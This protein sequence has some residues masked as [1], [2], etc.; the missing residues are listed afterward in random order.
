[1]IRKAQLD[2][3]YRTYNR[4]EFVHPD[5]IE[6]LYRYPDV[7]DREIAGVVA[8]VLAFG[9]VAQ[10]L[11]SVGRVLSPMGDSPCDWILQSTR[12][13]L[14]K[15]FKGFRHRF[16]GEAELIS[17][18]VAIR[19]L[20]RTHGSLHACFTTGLG[21]GDSDLR[22][23][24]ARFVS[25]LGPSCG[26]LTPSPSL[27]SACK[28]WNLFLRWMVRHDDV[29]PGGWDG[30]SPRLLIVPLDVH[31]ARIGRR[32]GFTARKTPGIRMAVDITEGFRTFSPNDPV[33]YD[34]ALT[35]FGIREE[36]D[37]D[38]LPQA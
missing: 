35:R 30:I 13:R 24:L 17:L 4:R 3:L 8:S 22:P 34:F 18:C 19:R 29:D 10:I 20:V 32:L 9:R 2:K 38:D 28:R 23:A 37:L 14:G 26:Y 12:S 25:E 6:F 33:K 16:V 21:H 31:M 11:R 36:L 1:M 27:G 5:P 7:R 15:T